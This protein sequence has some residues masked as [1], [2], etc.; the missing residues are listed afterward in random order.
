MAAPDFWNNQE[1]ARETV[2]QLKALRA[3]SS[4]WKRSYGTGS[5][6]PRHAGIGLRATTI[7]RRSSQ[8]NR[9]AG[10]RADELELKSL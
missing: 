5:D 9:A 1:K 3:S 10:A 2:G 7:R 4:R 8:R 6:L